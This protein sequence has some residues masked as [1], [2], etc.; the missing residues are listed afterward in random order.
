MLL[1]GPPPPSSIHSQGSGKQ[2]RGWGA[3]GGQGRGTALCSTGALGAASAT[4]PSP[5]DA[6]AFPRNSLAL[7]GSLFASGRPSSPSQVRVV[8]LCR[9]LSQA[10]LPAP[11]RLACSVSH[12]LSL[13]LT[14]CLFFSSPFVSRTCPCSPSQAHFLSSLPSSSR[15][16]VSLLS[17]VRSWQPPSPISQ[18]L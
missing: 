4:A 18:R 1:H 16:L 12:S 14:L 17:P 15:L 10:H 5:Q 9:P 2:P 13:S 7:P 3:A 11:A 8:G 6:T